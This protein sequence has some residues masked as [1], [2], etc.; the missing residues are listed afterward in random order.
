MIITRRSP[1]SGKFHQMD[2]PITSGQLARWEAGDPIQN[3]FPHL[4]AEQREFI[5]TGI[6]PEEWDA[7]F[8]APEKGDE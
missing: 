3:V 7:T 8:N 5:L 4:S 6:T 1:F 2:L